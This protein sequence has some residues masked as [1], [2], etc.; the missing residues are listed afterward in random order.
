MNTYLEKVS[1]SVTASS[2]KSWATATSTKAFSG[3]L[4]MLQLTPDVS[5]PLTAGSSS[6]WQLRADSTLG[7]VLS[8]SSSGAIGARAWYPRHAVHSSTAGKVIF[9]SSGSNTW[10][11]DRVAICNEKICLIKIAGATSAGGGSTEGI[12]A[13]IFV[14]GVHP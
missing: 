14:E 10:I 12:S 3:F 1:F 8:R 2:S 7:R 4:H 6:Y 9:N 13:A 11:T 5:N